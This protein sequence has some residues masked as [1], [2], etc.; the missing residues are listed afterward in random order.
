MYVCTYI[1]SYIHMCIFLMQK[2]THSES[3]L[4]WI[5]CWLSILDSNLTQEGRMELRKWNT[6]VHGHYNTCT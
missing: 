4:C 3:K 6:K 1:Q 5:L 2:Q